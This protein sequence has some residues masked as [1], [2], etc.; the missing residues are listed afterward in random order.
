MANPR[1][2]MFA[3]PTPDEIWGIGGLAEQQRELRETLK[4]GR[5]K[6]DPCK[7]ESRGFGRIRVCKTH[8][9]LR[10]AIE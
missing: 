3:D 1:K 8:G 7:E 2:P 5:R 10:E 4:E 9:K 6:N